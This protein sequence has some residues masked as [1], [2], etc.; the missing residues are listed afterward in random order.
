MVG[1]DVSR[2]SQLDTPATHREVES[3]CRRLIEFNTTNPPGNELTCASFIA[4]YLEKHGY[5]TRLVRHTPTRASVV[6]HLDGRGELPGLLLCGHL[7]VVPVGEERWQHSPFGAHL[8]GGRIWGRGSAD[9]KGGVAAIMSAAGLVAETAE[10]LKGDLWLAFTA[11]EEEELLGASEITR[12]EMIP[13]V[14]AIVIGEPTSNEVGI[15]GKGLLW[16]EIT[17]YGKTA[18]GSMPC[19]GRNAVNMMIEFLAEFGRLGGMGDPND[20]VLGAP[21]YN[22]GMISGG[23]KPNVVPDKCVATVDVRT[24]PGQDHGRITAELT[25]GLEDIG[26]RQDGF[27]GSIRAVKDLPPFGV[28]LN[29]PVVRRFSKVVRDAVGRTPRVGGVP[30]VTDG[31]VLAPALGAPLIICGPGAAAMAHRTDEYVEVNAVIDATRIFVGTAIEFL[32][33]GSQR[34]GPAG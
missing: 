7:D 8:D 2:K 9:M 13:P 18:H 31:A 27:R 33:G 32:G 11:G 29:H 10:Q 3:L 28:P 20:P 17:T 1:M 26:H 19:E 21:T 34:K 4:E 24:V 12:G 23:V 16:L 15:A 22:I 14:Q 30:Y 25:R 6:A 5:S